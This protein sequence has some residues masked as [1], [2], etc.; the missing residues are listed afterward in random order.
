MREAHFLL[1][2]RDEVGIYIIWQ[3]KKARQLILSS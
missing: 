2:Q 3:A 1:K